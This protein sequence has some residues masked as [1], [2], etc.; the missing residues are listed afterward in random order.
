MPN[1]KRLARLPGPQEK[2]RF[3]LEQSL[4]IHEPVDLLTAGLLVWVR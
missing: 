4:Q 3:F 1:Q 2:M